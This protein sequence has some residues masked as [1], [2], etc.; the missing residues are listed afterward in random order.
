MHY[1]YNP[2]YFL[3]TKIYTLMS[4]YFYIIYK[5]KTNFIK[6]KRDPRFSC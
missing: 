6:A 3:E 1:T 5:K 4:S 2:S